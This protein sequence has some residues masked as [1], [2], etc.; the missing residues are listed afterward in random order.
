L[1]SVEEIEMFSA[2]AKQVGLLVDNFQLRQRKERTAV[3]KERRRLARDLHDSVTQSLHSLTLAAYS[4]TNRLQQGRFDRL[5]EALDQISEGARRSLREMRLLLFEMRLEPLEK[6]DLLEALQL[7]LEAVEQRAGIDAQMT[8]EAPMPWPKAWEPDLYCITMESLNNAL[9]HSGAG[10]VRV[11]LSS[12]EKGLI[13]EVSDNGRG[14]D[15]GKIPAGGM[16]LHSLA[17]RV[18]RLGGT[19]QIESANGRGTRIQVR[20]ANV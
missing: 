18:E 8:V 10:Q 3:L 13:L 4:A 6:L 7:R 16:G 12:S 14:F 20:I 9:K 1:F 15:P 5:Q 2:L 17:E 11:C 19:L